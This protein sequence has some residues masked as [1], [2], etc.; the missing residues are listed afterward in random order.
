M[1]DGFYRRFYI[2]DGAKSVAKSISYFVFL[3]TL[4]NNLNIYFNPSTDHQALMDLF[5]KSLLIWLNL[6]VVLIE[7]TL[8]Y[9]FY[10]NGKPCFSKDR[11]KTKNNNVA[12]GY[13][14][15]RLII[16]LYIILLVYLVI[17]IAFQGLFNTKEQFIKYLSNG[18]FVCCLLIYFLLF[19]IAFVNICLLW[20]LSAV[21]IKSDTESEKVIYVPTKKIVHIIEIEIIEPFLNSMYIP[22][23]I[24]QIKSVNYKPFNT[25]LPDIC[26]DEDEL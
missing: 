10:D 15:T 22:N 25:D 17:T 5:A 21:E 16:G 11:R 7:F 12:M 24:L 9:P 13:C 4:L 18:F 6:L 23:S 14:A 3:A 8:V 19:I 26:K 2:F 20:L 1:L